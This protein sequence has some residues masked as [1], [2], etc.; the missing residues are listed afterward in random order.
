LVVAEF[1]LGGGSSS[2]SGVGNAA[3]TAGTGLLAAPIGAEGDSGASAASPGVGV[4]TLT[5]NHN[6]HGSSSS[7]VSGYVNSSL[8]SNSGN[9]GAPMTSVHSIGLDF[10]GG[11]VAPSV[12]VAQNNSA[13][14]VTS[15]APQGG[16][17]S[18]SKSVS[19]SSYSSDLSVNLA[20]EKRRRSGG[21]RSSFRSVSPSHAVFPSAPPA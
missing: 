4:C 3:L 2:A 17:R 5:G 6:R 14:P 11:P 15:A 13:V 1:N 7:G 20:K 19:V 10:A 16:S 21:S 12:S 18:R 9:T 8:S